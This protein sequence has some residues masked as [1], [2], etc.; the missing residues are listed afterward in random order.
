MANW[1]ELANDMIAK[2]VE[3]IEDFIVFSA[4]CTSWRTATPK[5]NSDVL[6]PQLPLL[7]L[8]YAKDC[9]YREFYSLSKK[10]V[11]RLYV[12]EAKWRTCFPSKGWLICF[13]QSELET[14]L[15]NPFSHKKIQLP[16]G[17]NLWPLQAIMYL[18]ITVWEVIIVWPIGDME[19]STGLKLIAEIEK[20][21][22]GQLVESGAPIYLAAEILELAENASSDNYKSRIIPRHSMLALKID[23][24]LFQE[25]GKLLASVTIASG[26]VL[27]MIIPRHLCWQ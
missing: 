3:V 26:D 13:L 24:Y 15:L 1:A 23:I 12:P 18:V 8:G 14:S 19:T 11:S 2:H 7:M 25:L 16:P 9:N 27:T 5:D 6:W 4:V 20:G 21:L 10:K 22:F 17:K